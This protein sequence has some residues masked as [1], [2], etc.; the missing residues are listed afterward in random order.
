MESYY[1]INGPLN[2]AMLE[3]IGEQAGYPNKFNPNNINNK[4]V[5]IGATT[6]RETPKIMAIAMAGSDIV[7][8]TTQVSATGLF[9]KRSFH[10]GFLSLYQK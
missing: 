5:Y 9:M 1:D 7:T 2:K 8:A 6:S 3:P 4:V 10:R